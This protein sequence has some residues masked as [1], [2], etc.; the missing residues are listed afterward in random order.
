MKSPACSRKPFSIFFLS[1]SLIAFPIRAIIS[2]A[3]TI[4]IASSRKTMPTI[5]WL[6]TW[7]IFNRSNHHRHVIPVAVV[8]NSIEIIIFPL[9]H[10]FFTLSARDSFPDPHSLL[11]RIVF[12]HGKLCVSIHL[13]LGWLACQMTISRTRLSWSNDVELCRGT[14]DV[15]PSPLQWW[16]FLWMNHPATNG[17]GKNQINS[18][19]SG[20]FFYFSFFFN[21][22]L[23]VALLFWFG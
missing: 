9:I 22:N 5:M 18:F 14:S 20:Y 19:K 8:E 2:A 16:G 21:E 6:N 11:V 17:R 3:R 13:S 1:L 12:A 10:L 7:Q 23:W 15:C 4:I